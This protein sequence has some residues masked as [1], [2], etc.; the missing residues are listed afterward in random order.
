MFWICPELD[1]EERNPKRC[2]RSLF[3]S[4]SVIIIIIVQSKAEQVFEN[5]WSNFL[6]LRLVHKKCAL[7]IWS[8]FDV[9]CK[10]KL[11][12]HPIRHKKCHILFLSLD[13]STTAGV[14]WVSDDSPTFFLSFF[15]LDLL[16]IKLFSVWSSFF[17]FS[18]K[19]TG[20]RKTELS[21]LAGTSTYYSY[22]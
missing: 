7:K 9:N 18:L 8:I 4:I 12:T 19:I 20:S 5:S 1:M 13:F 22:R 2:G 14:E 21:Y 15:L 11:L 10:E 3:R 6:L 16:F 17:F